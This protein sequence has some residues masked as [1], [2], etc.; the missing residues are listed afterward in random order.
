M[1]IVW[2]RGALGLS[3][4]GEGN[5]PLAGAVWGLG[6]SPRKAPQVSEGSIKPARFK[7][8][9]ESQNSR[10]TGLSTRGGL[11]RSSGEKSPGI[12]NAVFK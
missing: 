6:T 9:G 10:R 5:L 1:Q 3:P 12:G 8:R 2:Q 11:V 7:G 4:E